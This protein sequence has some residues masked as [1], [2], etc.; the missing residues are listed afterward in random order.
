MDNAPDI[1]SPEWRLWIMGRL[2]EIVRGHPVDADVAAIVGRNGSLTRTKID[3][4]ITANDVELKASIAVAVQAQ[5]DAIGSEAHRYAD[6]RDS[7]ILAEAK[8]YTDNHSGGGGVAASY[9]DAGDVKAL[10][11]AKLAI[12]AAVSNSSTTLR[13][14]TDSAASKALTDAKSSAGAA[15]TEIL[16]LAKVYTDGKPSGGGVTETQLNNAVSQGLED[17]ATAATLADTALRNELRQYANGAASGSL[18]DAAEEAQRLATEAGATAVATAKTY[19][20][21]T[22]ESTANGILAAVDSKIDVYPVHAVEPWLSAIANKDNAPARQLSIGDS[23]TEGSNSDSIVN[24]WV[25]KLVSLYRK[26]YGQLATGGVGHIPPYYIGGSMGQPFTSVSNPPPATDTSFGFGRRCAVMS[27]AHFYTFTITASSFW[28]WYV[29]GPSTGTIAVSID[30][31]PETF[32]NTAASPLM[33]GKTWNSPALSSGSH[34]VKVRASAGTIYFTGLTVFNGDE[35]SGFQMFEAGH[36]GWKTTDWANNSGYWPEIVS[37]VQPQLV[38]IALMTNDYQANVNPATC[39]TNLLNMISG[40]KQKLN[41]P[42]TILIITYPA[43]GDVS[44]PQYGWSMYVNVAKEISD[45]DETV[46][47]LDLS[48]RY[49]SPA[50]SNILNNWDGDLVHPTNKGHAVIA[51]SIFSYLNHA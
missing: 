7:L 14:Y 29:Q 46:A 17:A 24:R 34:T 4:M 40:I 8:Q 3:D 5:L 1:G 19:T 30:D 37:K 13:Q 48:K 51:E 32:I 43:R 10:A 2:A 44:N 22:I 20:D 11:D 38:T 18:E 15:D 28:L 6:T 16:R 31:G 12:T 49:T 25:Q 35:N 23:I 21:D 45:S 27:G 9:V 36:W 50:T 47:H 39:K 33:D 26:R 42:A 41:K